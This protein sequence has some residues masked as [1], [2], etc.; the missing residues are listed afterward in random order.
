MPNKWIRA[1]KIFNKNKPKWVVPKKG[2]KEH[3]QVKK[4]MATLK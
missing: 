1:L 2:T 3:K 4:I